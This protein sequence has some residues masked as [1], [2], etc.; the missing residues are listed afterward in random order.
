M[1]NTRKKIY[2][3]EYHKIEEN[4][5]E[6]L[7]VIITFISLVVIFLSL[8]VDHFQ[9]L[10]FICCFCAVLIAFLAM[11]MLM[12]RFILP[13]GYRVLATNRMMFKTEGHHELSGQRIEKLT[14]PAKIALKLEKIGVAF[15][16]AEM[17]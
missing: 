12:T 10:F 1:K 3:R 8:G 6:G 15:D 9:G 11:Y 13:D 16:R 14:L 4:A 5:R 17:R 2:E 7:K